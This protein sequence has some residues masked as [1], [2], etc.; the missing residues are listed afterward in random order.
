[1]RGAGYPYG[2]EFP[3]LL[4]LFS[5]SPPRSNLA[6][7]PADTKACRHQSAPGPATS[8]RHVLLS[9]S[10]VDILLVSYSCPAARHSALAAC[11]AARSTIWGCT[12]LVGL[13]VTRWLCTHPKLARQLGS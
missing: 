2:E 9:R 3:T 8:S 4:R 10:V 7:C 11:A 12:S 6:I 13:S 5:L 1:M